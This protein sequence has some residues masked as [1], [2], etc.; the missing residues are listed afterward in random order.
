MIRLLTLFTALTAFS[1]SA[2]AQDLGRD[3]YVRLV[4]RGI[5]KK[6]AK[7]SPGFEA[8]SLSCDID[9]CTSYQWLAFRG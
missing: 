1:V 5:M 4:G 9:S 7:K 8:I 2:S 3:G 6:P